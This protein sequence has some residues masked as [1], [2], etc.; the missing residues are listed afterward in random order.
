SLASGRCRGVGEIAAN[1]DVTTSYVMRV[2]PLAFLAPDIVEAIVAGKAPSGL[3]AERL[4]RMGA[5][6]V[7]WDAQRAVLGI[8]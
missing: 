2:M 5:L 7:A 4:R 6:P 8:D 1:H 3:T